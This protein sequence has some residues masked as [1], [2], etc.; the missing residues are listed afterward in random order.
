[1]IRLNSHDK[2]PPGEF[3]YSQDSKRFG[4]TPLIKELAKRV[5][6]FRSGNGLPGGTFEQAL[7]DI[8]AYTCARLNNSPDWCYDTERSFAETTPAIGQKSGGCASCGA[9]I[10]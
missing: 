7:Q 1:M 5:A 2:C 9:K 10:E 4:A 8:D 3:Y 6:N